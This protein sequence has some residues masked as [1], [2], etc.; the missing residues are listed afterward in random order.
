M[1]VVDPGV[2]VHRLYLDPHF[3]KLRKDN[4]Q[5]NL[6]KCVFGVRSEKLLT[7]DCEQSFQRGIKPNPDKIE[8]FQAMESPKT[9]KE[10]QR[11][12][13]RIAALTRFISQAKDRSLPFFKATKK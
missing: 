2:A 9:Q 11:L 10:A 7:K 13:G 3:E 8:A 5:L 1:S 12:T 4:L 6:D